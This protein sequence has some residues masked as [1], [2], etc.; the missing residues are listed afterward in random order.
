MHNYMMLYSYVNFNHMNN[1]YIVI[2]I[3]LE[4]AK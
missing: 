2:L 3:V 1:S 4:H